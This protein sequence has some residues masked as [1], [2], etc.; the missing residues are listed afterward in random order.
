MQKDLRVLLLIDTSQVY[1]SELI[2]GITKY[3][4]LHGSWTFYTDIPFFGSA[5]K[6]SYDFSEL[7]GLIVHI[8][9]PKVIAK[10]LSAGLPAIVRGLKSKVDGLPNF[11]GDNEAISNMAAEHLLGLG[12]KHFGFC[13]YKGVK[14]SQERGSCFAERLG[15]AGFDVQFCTLSGSRQKH[16][17]R[18][19]QTRLTKCLQKLPKPAGVFACNDDMGAHVLHACRAEGIHVPDELAVM[20]VDNEINICELANPPLSSI[21]RNFEKAGY[22][23][24]ELLHRLILGRKPVFQNVIV[25]PTHVISRQSTDVLAVS[26][27][28]VAEA[29]RFIRANSAR[30]IS[31]EDVLDIVPLSRR[32]LDHKFLRAFGHSIHGEITRCRVERIGEMLLETDLTVSQIAYDLGFSG[33]DHI[34]RYFRRHKGVNPSIYRRKYAHKE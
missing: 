1:G 12:L 8:P 33:P 11:V 17:W 13:G 4:R 30:P 29:V 20:G 16:F 21:A 27:K 10:A 28:T 18:N 2:A 32:Y 22:R 26:D 24:M 25:G 5:R 31:V 9:D 3:A 6:H 34:G 19:E 15:R 14:W 7:D 23:A